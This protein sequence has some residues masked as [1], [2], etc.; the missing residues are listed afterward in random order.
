[1]SKH[2]VQ[3]TWLVWVFG[4]GIVVTYF[5]MLAH[6]A[7]AEPDESRYAEIAREM[8]DLGDWVTPHLNYV[9][10]FEKPPL[11]YWLTALSF[12]VFGMSEFVVRLWPALFGVL[13]I[14]TAYV[15]G[16][17][18]YGT[19]VGQIAAA[20]LATAPFYFGISQIVILDMPLSA[21]M[22]AALGA[23]WI[24]YADAR[25]R[26]LG[27]V[28]LY[29][30]TAFA[31]LIKGPVAA[32]LTGGVIL[33]FLVLQGSLRALR[34]VLSPLGIC[35]FLAIAAPWF[36]LVS[37]RNPEFVDFFV[38]KQHLDRF[39]RPDEHREPL[40]FFA[41]L[42]FAGLLPWSGF[43]LFAPRALGRFL[44]RLVTR[45]VSPGTLY[46]VVWSGLIFTFF[47]LSGS[48]LA[49]YVLPIF[50]PLAVLMA[51]FFQCV[52]D[53][54][55]VNLLRSGCIALL[56]VAG[57][58]LAAALVSAEVIDAPLMPMILPRAYAG[59][60]VLVLASIAALILLR[61][62]A[63]QP[64][65]AV[66]LFGMLAVQMVAISGRGIAAQYRPLG[67]TIRQQAA[68]QDLVV[69]YRHYVQGITFYARRRAIMVD[70][71][72]ELDFGSR[73]G[74]QQAFFW[75]TDG[76][77]LDAWHSDRRVFLVINRSE[78]EPLRAQ[79]GPGFR[80]IAAHGKKVVVTN[81][82]KQPAVGS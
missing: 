79:L 27:V 68:A 49:T 22:A 10:Y 2:G 61:R 34:W 69:I 16:R 13:G 3:P 41:P 63:V 5:S 47:S 54:H 6:F 1:V 12:R 37:R 14:L 18:M 15:V 9:K 38:I 59:A 29:V 19:A 48:K 71:R 62:S 40:W 39:L 66:L 67:L 74:N 76:Q 80:E 81:F 77:L 4:L 72:G 64:G 26:R 82:A 11:I 50:C 44:R 36:V 45:R 58:S 57:V 78:L 46:C 75:D 65:F 60:G 23:F 70:G 51:R 8:L 21:V 32:I 52:L 25:R 56:G 31:V 35:L 55:E 43:V 53:R 30:A 73:Q 28:G 24:A 20:L 17:S 42:V 7:L 33:S